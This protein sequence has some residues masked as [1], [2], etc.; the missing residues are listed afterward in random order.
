MRRSAS[1]GDKGRENREGEGEERDRE[2]SVDRES[3]KKSEAVR[4]SEK[5][6]APLPLQGGWDGCVHCTIDCTHMHGRVAVCL[7]VCAVETGRNKGKKGRRGARAPH[8]SLQG[9]PAAH[10]AHCA[11]EMF[12]TFVCSCSWPVPLFLS[13]F[14]YLVAPAVASLAA[15]ALAAPRGQ[16]SPRRHLRPS[17]SHPHVSEAGRS[18]DGGAVSDCRRFRCHQH[19][20]GNP[21]AS[22]EALSTTEWSTADVGPQ[23]VAA[24]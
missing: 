1:E 19:P 4:E 5:K 21:F 3:E 6:S 12:T 15:S 7:P 8:R 13:F 11:P 16:P 2:G 23:V 24:V 10:G 20:H 14:L 22:V 9:R 17:P 18:T